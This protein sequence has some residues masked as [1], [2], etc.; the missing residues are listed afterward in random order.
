MDLWRASQFEALFLWTEVADYWVRIVYAC[1]NSSKVKGI[2]SVLQLPGKIRSNYLSWQV[3]PDPSRLS[4]LW[5]H[6]RL[7]YTLLLFFHMLLLLWSWPPQFKQVRSLVRSLVK[8][9]CAQSTSLYPTCTESACIFSCSRESKTDWTLHKARKEYWIHESGSV[10]CLDL[11]LH[12]SHESDTLDG[13]RHL[14]SH[15]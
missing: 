11:W 5:V 1:T 6:L 2:D 3:P 12:Y 7:Q 14:H 9:A 13:I 15:K 4:L 10:N 8:Y